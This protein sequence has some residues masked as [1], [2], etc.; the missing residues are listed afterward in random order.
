MKRLLTVLLMAMACSMAFAESFI[1][2]IG[3]GYTYMRYTTLSDTEV[4]LVEYSD[5][6]DKGTVTVPSYVTS[7]ATS[8]R[9]KVVRIGI[10][11][12]SGR[13]Y[14][15]EII[16]PSEIR[17]IGAKAFKDCIRLE[18]LTV[19][20]ETTEIDPTAFDNCP[21]LE[22]VSVAE[23]NTSY[24]IWAGA[25]MDID[26]TILIVC[27]KR[28]QTQ[29]RFIFPK[30][31]KEVTS[32]AFTY[33]PN[34]E[35]FSI[36]PGST[37]AKVV[38]GVL[39]DFALTKLLAFPRAKKGNL[40]IPS[41][42]ADLEPKT[43]YKASGLVDVT[44]PDGLDTLKEGMFRECANLRTVGLPAGLHSIEKEAFYGCGNLTQVTWP[45]SLA[46]I[47]ENAFYECSKLNGSVNLPK[48]QSIEDYAFYRCYSIKSLN[49][50]EELYYLGD[51]A[52][53]YCIGIKSLKIPGSLKAVGPC[54]GC[55]EKCTDIESVELGDGLTTIFAEMFLGLSSL[56]KIEIPASV[57]SIKSHAFA[58]SGL[59]SIFIP[60][61]VTE[62]GTGVFDNCKS[63]KTVR[64]SA[65]SEIKA[66]TYRDCSSLKKVIWPGKITSLG[67]SAFQNCSAFDSIIL[68]EGITEIGKNVFKGCTGA[69]KLSLPST[70]ATIG[71]GAFS[72]CDSL[73][74]VVNYAAVPQTITD[75]VFT[76]YNTLCVLDGSL[77]AYRSA[78]GWYNFYIIGGADN[79]VDGIDGGEEAYPV[80]YY[81]PA[82][83][84]VD[85]NCRGI[86]IV[87]MSD[88]TTRKVLR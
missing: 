7:S 28:S 74:Y 39:Y 75:N 3:S 73:A 64:L 72:G 9:Y 32:Y 19:P 13:L 61:N 76:T 27:P 14:I 40:V 8:K 31:I 30:T 88:G 81:T 44:L 20:K 62:M 43:F 83:M 42:V 5:K 6:L 65:A 35:E 69:K 11:A 67:S 17:S 16:L 33:C 68:P 53:A 12:F 2:Y 55:F 48:V 23:G 10:G 4:A 60:D 57:K 25:L 26:K 84:R 70:L 24:C 36:E 29:T 50:G 87:R 80:D 45:D 51:N 66:Y 54:G 41:T 59:D 82:G 46:V 77:Q 85:E 37:T 49:L 22:S 78:Y 71:D 21:A 52:F 79:G 1:V 34:F 86:V 56:R 18:R 63:L 47:Q 58:Y 38:D 15:N